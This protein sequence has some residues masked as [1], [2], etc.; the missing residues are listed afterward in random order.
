MPQ[1]DDFFTIE[2][3]QIMY[4]NFTGVEGP[5]NR[6]GDRNFAAIL[7][8]DQGA[9]LHRRGWNVKRTKPRE[10]EEEGRPFIPVAVRYKGR[11]PRIVLITSRGRTAISEEEVD[12]LDWLDIRSVDMVLRPYNWAVSGNTGIK[13]YLK[14]MFVIIDEDPIERK[15][16][17]LD[18]TPEGN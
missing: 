4:R 16:A 13:A 6:E 3:G 10:G 11:P 7:T 14:T 12:M 1:T 2:D 5:M 9:E 8:E 17:E 15:Y 18:N